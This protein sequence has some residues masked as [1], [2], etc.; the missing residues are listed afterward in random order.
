[1]LDRVRR[2]ARRALHV[3]RQ[4]LWCHDCGNYVQFDIDMEMDGN[5][6]LECP[7]CG[8]E[9]CRVVR[10]GRITDIRWGSRNGP[11]INVS[12]ATTTC[13]TASTFDTYTSTSTSGTSS[14]FLY[15]SW[16]NRS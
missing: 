2:A 13:S 15:Q 1:M 8:H 5:H 3:E 9:H 10:D 7:S 16:M 14:S 4:E 11:T 6:V 12:A